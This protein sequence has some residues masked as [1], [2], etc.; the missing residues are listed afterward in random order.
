[1]DTLVS[2]KPLGLGGHPAASTPVAR[3]GAYS[4]LLSVGAELYKLRKRPATWLLAGLFALVIV[5][6][7]D[8]ASS[9]AL[10][11]VSATD[12]DRAGFRDLTLF[13]NLS[14]SALS[15][16]AMLGGPIV[17]ILGALI[18]GSEYGW[19]TF[20]TILTQGPSRLTIF[21][22]KVV[23]LAVLVAGFVIL[24]WMA[25]A[26][27][28]L[29]VSVFESTPVAMPSLGSLVGGLG[30]GWFVA[31]VWGTVGLA[32]GLI[33]R[34]TTVPIGLGLIW[35]LAVESI[36]AGLAGSVSIF[37]TIQDYLIGPNASALAVAVG[38]TALG[39]DSTISTTHA[40]LVLTGYVVVLV[41]IAASLFRTRDL[42]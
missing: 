26:A 15:V 6:F 14:T 40:L 5:V 22:S 19:T 8:V 33:F 29:V 4:L 12:P 20:K 9:I 27:G 16:V 1:M 35:G 7:N 32:L 2:T 30:A 39:G 13:E 17:L 42:T 10:Q 41:G 21:G 28:S 25:S 24:G 38:V 23:S 18:S 34:T 31:M 11:T 37:A 36:I 3:N